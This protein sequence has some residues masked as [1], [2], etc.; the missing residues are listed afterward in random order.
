TH[1][2]V[3]AM[4]MG[5]RVAVM[6]AG[7]LQQV[8]TPLDLYEKPVNPFVA[9]F[10]GSPAMTL[11]TFAVT[12][13]GVLVGDAVVPLSRDTLAGAPAGGEVV[14]GVRAEPLEDCNESI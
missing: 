5:D 7:V 6:D 13:G 8:G 4:T 1:D 3:E 12:D 11:G 10:I 14:L 9:G 2:Q